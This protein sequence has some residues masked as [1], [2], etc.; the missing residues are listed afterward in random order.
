MK[1]LI[2]NTLKKKII[3]YH[4]QIQNHSKFHIK[5][6]KKKKHYTLIIVSKN[7]L[8][9]NLLKRHQFVYNILK[10]YFY[11]YIASLNLYLYTVPEWLKQHTKT[12]KNFLCMRDLHS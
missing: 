4:I 12:H 5:K 10:I 7:F 6:Q 1:N 8:K 2:L 11:E 3:L 9:M